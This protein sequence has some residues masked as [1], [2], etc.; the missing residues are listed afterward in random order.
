MG[1][2]W[3]RDLVRVTR[4]FANVFPYVRHLACTVRVLAFGGVY[5]LGR[6]VYLFVASDRPRS[7]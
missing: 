5:C 6:G 4:A 1:Q 2:M 7:S 3:G